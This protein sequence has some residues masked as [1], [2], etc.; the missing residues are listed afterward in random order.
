VRPVAA[1]HWIVFMFAP[2]VDARA[3]GLRLPPQHRNA[4]LRT[5]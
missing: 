1:M 4:G 3:D 2:F 5:A